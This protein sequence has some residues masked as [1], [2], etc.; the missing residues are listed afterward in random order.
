MNASPVEFLTS[1]TIPRP[2][3]C[4]YNNFEHLDRLAKVDVEGSSPFSR[5]KN[6]KPDE[7]FLV[8]LFSFWAILIN[9]RPLMNCRLIFSS[10][11][12]VHFDPCCLSSV[13]RN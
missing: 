10:R 8:G 13:R 7:D 1:K 5:S 11:G 3:P 4:F 6:F 2:I 9:S 12:D